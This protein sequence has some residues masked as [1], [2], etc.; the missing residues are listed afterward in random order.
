LLM[1]N[2]GGVIMP[3]RKVVPPPDGPVTWPEVFS[4]LCRCLVLAA[5]LVAIVYVAVR[6]F[7]LKL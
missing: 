6:Y 3:W 1:V 7:S 4:V 5:M 2:L